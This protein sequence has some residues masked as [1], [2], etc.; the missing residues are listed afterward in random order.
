MGI[1]CE[2]F[3]MF[4]LALVLDTIESYIFESVESNTKREM[5]L[6][7]IAQEIFSKQ[8]F[9]KDIEVKIKDAILKYQGK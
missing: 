2:S 1:T 6:S 5:Q 9:L 7:D 3:F 4:C 8:G